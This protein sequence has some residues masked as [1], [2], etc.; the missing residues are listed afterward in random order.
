MARLTAYSELTG[1][2]GPLKSLARTTAQTCGVHRCSIFMSSDGFL[3]PVMSQLA[4]GER[5]E[6]LWRAFMTLGPYRIEEIPSFVR[7]IEERRP[8]VL[9]E[10]GHECAV[11]GQ[12]KT[13]GAASAALIPLLGECGIV[14][15]MVLDSRAPGISRDQV[16]RSRDAARSIA[17]VIDGAL[18]VIEMRDQLRDAE[19]VVSLGRSMGATREVQDV[20]RRITELYARAARVA[21]DTERARVDNLLHDTVRQTLFSIALRIERSLR[22]RQTTSVL[23]AYLGEIKRDVGVIMTQVNQLVTFGPMLAAVSESSSWSERREL[24]DGSASPCPPPTGERPEALAAS[25]EESGC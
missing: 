13:F 24:T 9:P 19:T 4:S 23:R 12:W 10:P 6:Q 18:T 14:G 22:G 11:P 15:M 16:R 2:T 8:V 21:L 25:P 17:C 3:V 5:H 20:V 7:A 1:L